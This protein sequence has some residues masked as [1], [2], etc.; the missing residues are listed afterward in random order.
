MT[1]KRVPPVD[2]GTVIGYVRASTGR[3]ELGPQAQ[4]VAL[5]DWCQEHKA[6]LV[7]VHEDRG[8]SGSTPIDHRPGLLAAF[9]GL[10][11]RGAGVLLVARRDRLARDPLVALM[12]ERLAERSGAMVCSADG[13]G[14]GHGPE[15]ELMRRVLDAV[16]QFERSLIRLRIR[17]A[18]EVKRRRGEKLGGRVPYGYRLARD[19]RRLEPYQPEQRVIDRAKALRA[20]GMPLRSVARA[21]EEEGHMP[22][23]GRKW[24][25]QSIL[26]ITAARP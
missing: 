8:V 24:H 17:S 26:R 25:Q 23:S 9:D 4:R 13:Q 16:A 5:K 11:A 7:A 15:G 2:P 19:R 21:L 22:R 1:K 12:A 10:R 3:Q 18:L 20:S 14:N 6:T